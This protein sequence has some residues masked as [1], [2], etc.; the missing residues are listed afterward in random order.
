MAICTR[1]SPKHWLDTFEPKCLMR[2]LTRLIR[3][4]TPLKL[5]VL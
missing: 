4:T 3:P 1:R 5:L 2:R